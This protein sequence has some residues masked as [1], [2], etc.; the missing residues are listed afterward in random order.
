M[1]YRLFKKPCTQNHLNRAASGTKSGWVSTPPPASAGRA[2][3][4]GATL[5]VRIREAAGLTFT[6]DVLTTRVAP[7]RTRLIVHPRPKDEVQRFTI[8]GA[9]IDVQ[10][11]QELEIMFRS[12]AAGE[13]FIPA[14]A[15]LERCAPRLPSH[16]A[17]RVVSNLLGPQ[18]KV[19]G[20]PD[21]L[22]IMYE[23]K[24]AG[25]DY[26]PAIV[27]L[28]RCAPRLPSRGAICVVSNHAIQLDVGRLYSQWMKVGDPSPSC[29]GL[30]LLSTGCMTSSRAPITIVQHLVDFFASS[31]GRVLFKQ[32][33]VITVEWSGEYTDSGQKSET[34]SQLPRTTGCTLSL[35][36]ALPSAPA[37]VGSGAHVTF[38]LSG[39][40]L[41][42]TQGAALPKY[43]ASYW[44]FASSLFHIE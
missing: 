27:E 41:P 17:I 5:V 39:P 23:T 6:R 8:V 1:D 2:V 30:R 28:E 43:P 21:Q 31:T 32:I 36:K 14:I 37:N 15:E 19:Q 22:D 38:W 4:T 25:E 20:K 24:A 40:P 44:S 26:I 3:R 12:P 13:D 16:G 10:G 34:P 29:G 9:K 18:I 11:K 35:T 7:V 33:P 42:W